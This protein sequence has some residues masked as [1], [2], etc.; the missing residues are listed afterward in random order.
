MYWWIVL[1]M[2]LLGNFIAFT[3]T[4][5]YW[6]YVIKLLDKL[7]SCGAWDD[8]NRWAFW[9][10]ITVGPWLLATIWIVELIL[11]ASFLTWYFYLKKDPKAEKIGKI[12]F[13]DE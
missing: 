4:I 5:T 11:I 3:L 6:K 9:L 7:K 10:G 8:D 2:G 1:V 13:E 12:L